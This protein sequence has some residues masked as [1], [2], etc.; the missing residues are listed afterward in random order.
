MKMYVG[1][2]SREISEEELRNEFKGYGAV[3]SVALIKDR[4][5]GMLKGFG[6]VEMPVRREAEAAVAGLNDKEVRGR[7]MVVNEARPK[8]DRGGYGRY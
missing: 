5:T 3:D 1:N 6:F 8:T 2:L 4:D 7:K